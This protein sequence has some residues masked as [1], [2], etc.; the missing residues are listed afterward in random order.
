M[1]RLAPALGVLALAAAA[2]A[3]GAQQ[4]AVFAVL[5]FE[6]SGSYGQDR[7]VFEALE[8]GIPVLLARALDRHATADVAEQ[9]RVLRAL[10][11]LGLGP[12]QRVDAQSAAQ[13][14]QAAGARYTVTGSFADFYGKFRVNARVVDGRTGEILKVV[15]ND[16]PRLQ[17]RAQL[18]AILQAVSG[19]I[20]GAAGLTAGDGGGGPT[21]PT[22]AITDFSRGLLHEQRGDRARALEFYQR[23]ARAAP[24]F[25]EARAGARRVGG[26]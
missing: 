5:P 8:L 26:A 23:A 21:L 20:L 25:E 4:R 19:K 12:G 16:E 13:V 24:E 7:E 10:A 2:G 6:N 14:A 11:G 9:P 18:W 17:D 3:A 15:S 22:E 1:I